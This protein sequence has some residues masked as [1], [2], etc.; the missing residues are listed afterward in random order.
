M[1]AY[2][3]CLGGATDG[4][5]YSRAVL[6]VERALLANRSGGPSSFNATTFLLSFFLRVF[7]TL[8]LPLSLLLLDFFDWLT[9]LS[10]ALLLIF[11][12]QKYIVTCEVMRFSSNN[13]LT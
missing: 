5:M 8:Q 13:S 12:T 3:I 4:L 7:V 9:E 1:A 10:L 2:Q 6:S 11:S